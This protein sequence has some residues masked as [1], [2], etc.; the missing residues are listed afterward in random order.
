MSARGSLSVVAWPH[1]HLPAGLP[2]VPGLPARL[3]RVFWDKWCSTQRVQ[4]FT[5]AYW[6][7]GSQSLPTPARRQ[8]SQWAHRP[9]RTLGAIRR[10]SSRA[11][12]DL[13]AMARLTEPD[14]DA[15]PRARH[16]QVPAPERA[17]P[18][19]GRR[20]S[21]SFHPPVPHPSTA[22]P[23]GRSPRTL[24]RGPTATP[25]D[26]PAVPA[27]PPPSGPGPRAAQP[28][29]SQVAR[30]RPQLRE[31]DG[32]NRRHAGTVTWSVKGRAPPPP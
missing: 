19:G 31:V 17:T 9:S 12:T 8:L 29:R 32:P 2:A 13:T 30:L 22:G 6:V 24:L 11:A 7:I 25:V 10:Q 1:W 3:C 4:R 28:R 14:V 16:L 5:L 15:A 18:S 20:G 23:P 27:S 26:E 21:A